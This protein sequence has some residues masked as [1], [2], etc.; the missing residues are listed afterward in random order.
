[1]PKM[2]SGTFL[3][4]VSSRINAGIVSF[5]HKIG[6]FSLSFVISKSTH[7]M[8]FWLGFNRLLSFNGDPPECIP[9]KLKIF[10]T[11]CNGQFLLLLTRQRIYSKTSWSLQ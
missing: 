10:Q 9:R 1:M 3:A 4:L 2:A 7:N 6:F 8:R 5:E 11:V